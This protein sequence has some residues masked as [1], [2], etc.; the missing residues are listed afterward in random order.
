M[1]M[2]DA[3]PINFYVMS[4][5]GYFYNLGTLTAISA[6]VSV[7][8]YMCTAC[9]VYTLGGGA[10]NFGAIHSP[11]IEVAHAF[12]DSLVPVGFLYYGEGEDAAFAN[13]EKV[14]EAARARTVPPLNT[15]AEPFR[16]LAL[17]TGGRRFRYHVVNMTVLGD[18]SG[19]L[20]IG[21]PMYTPPGAALF[22]GAGARVF[23]LVEHGLPMHFGGGRVEV[24]SGG[25]LSYG[26]IGRLD[27]GG[28]TVVRAGGK[29]RI[30]THVHAVIGNYS[31]R[32][33]CGATVVLN[34]H[35]VEATTGSIKVCHQAPRDADATEV[36]GLALARGTA[37][38]SL[39]K[40]AKKV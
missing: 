25:A 8:N 15:M 29:L 26:I 11:R 10:F 36:R 6:L 32:A 18:G 9:T 16:R 39:R 7:T 5:S 3:Y 2:A 35:L 1:N 14:S 40:F 4:W 37:P 20:T 31:V 38:F 17:A 30:P 22:V 13:L 33:E 34:G 12:E 21:A 19:Q 28:Q 23:F 24:L 27:D